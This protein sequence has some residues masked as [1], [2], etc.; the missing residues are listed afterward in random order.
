MKETTKQNISIL[1]ITLLIGASAFLFIKMIRPALSEEKELKTKVKE[2]EEKIVLLKEYK[3]KSD[4][5]IDNYSKLGD[6]IANI[7]FALPDKP[8]TAEVLAIL[9]VISKKLGITLNTIVFKE[10]IEK[11]MN[12]LEIRTSF[13]ASYDDFKQWAGEIE[14]ELRL[15]DFLNTEVKFADISQQVSSSSAKKKTTKTLPSPVLEY[16]ITL[17]T[18]YNQSGNEDKNAK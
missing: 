10:G 12:F 18:Y 2:A 5:L 16:N 14:K 4:V 1:I 6:Q 3:V 8:E 17:W 13:S 7:N 9:D 11:E 15:M